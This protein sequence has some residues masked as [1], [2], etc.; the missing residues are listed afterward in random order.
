MPD[1]TA[2]RPSAQLA[3]ARRRPTPTPAGWWFDVLLLAALA[4]LT[5]A[6]IAG[7]FLDTDVAVRDWV[8]ANRPPVAYWAARVLNYFGQGGSVLIPVSS[9][10]ALWLGRRVRS[11]RPA[12]PVLAAVASTYL[13]VGA[14]KVL[15]PRA[16]PRN[17][18]DPF[19]ERLFTEATPAMAYPSGHVANAV[20]WYA[21]IALLITALRR[22][23]G[24]PVPAG[25][26]FP[27]YWALRLLPAV[28]IFCTTVYLGYH[29][30]TDSVAGLL[31]GWLLLR[32]LQRVPWDTVRLPWVRG[33]L[34]RP[35]GLS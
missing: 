23:Y 9:L 31:L 2:S 17:F 32:L 33:G 30:L 34:D 8:E 11:V 16:Y 24:R 18:E 29:W 10:L 28:V 4:G 13:S 20:I 22:S 3:D 6:L 7:V 5:G 14:M 1:A 15:L 25:R 27:G 35:A 12:L 21:V 19:P 26:P